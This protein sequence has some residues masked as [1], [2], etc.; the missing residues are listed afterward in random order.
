MR[1]TAHQWIR[2]LLKPGR[3]IT[4]FILPFQHCCDDIYCDIFVF[5]I[6]QSGKFFQIVRR[7]HFLHFRQGFYGRGTYP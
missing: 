6:Q 4:Q 2:M 3:Q 5:V 1:P 7:F